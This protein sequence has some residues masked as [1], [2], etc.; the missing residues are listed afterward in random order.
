MTRIVT[1]FLFL[2]LT[3]STHIPLRRARL[4]YSCDLLPFTYLS[5]PIHLVDQEYICSYVVLSFGGWGRKYSWG[6]TPEICLK[7]LLK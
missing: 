5:P 2:I 7:I 6:V 3:I 4:Y 1:D